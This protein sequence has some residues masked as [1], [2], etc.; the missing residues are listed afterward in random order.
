M[1]QTQSSALFKETWPEKTEAAT[2]PNRPCAA[3]IAAAVLGLA[4]AWF[5]AG[6]IGMM[7]HPMHRGAA[8]IA[9][10]MAVV[11]AWPQGG[12]WKSLL[13]ILAVAGA[14]AA[15]LMSSAILPLNVLAVALVLVALSLGHTSSSKLALQVAAESVLLLA[16]FRIAET[17]IPWVWSGADGL[18][19]FLGTI[20]SLMSAKPLWVGATFG[21]LDFL[22]PMLYLAI[23]APLRM[24][25]S[26]TLPVGRA[27][28]ATAGV[29]AVVSVLLV[30]LVALSYAPSILELPRMQ[31]EKVERP[32]AGAT[33]PPP[34]MKTILRLMIPWNV[35]LLAG[36]FEAVV[37]VC[38]LRELRARA[39]EQSLRGARE[40]LW[41]MDMA[42]LAIVLAVAAP[43]AVVYHTR[44]PDMR[45]KKIV[46]HE[47]GFL[48]WLKPEHGQYGRLSIGMYG[49]M[50]TYLQSLGARTK[51]SP[52]LSRE[53]LK[54]A[55]AVVLLFSNERWK[56]GQLE[57]LWAFVKG[58]GTLLVMGEH[59][60]CEKDVDGNRYDPA[61]YDLF[62]F[63]NQAIEPTKMRVRFDAA[64]FAIGGWLHSYD[65][66]AHPTTAGIGD[67]RNEIGAVIGASV[68]AE[69]PARPLVVGRWGW[70]DAGDTRNT[71]RAMLGDDKYNAGE[72]LGDVLL[73]AEQP[74]GRGKVIV[75]GDTSGLTNGLTVGCHPYTSRLYA[76][77]CDGTTGALPAWTFAVSLA[78]LSAVTLVV[79][80]R[81]QP[82]V[83]AA[84]A[85]A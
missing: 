57:R 36:L 33:P 5:A 54:D 1:A 56:A 34:P 25:R 52:D 44:A 14:A 48:N 27:R 72:K 77:L 30:Y 46:M 42:A 32:V 41:D 58:G 74:F 19:G 82:M 24:D 39:G 65:P 16:L 12:R 50:E 3:V 31:A 23:A 6:S 79:V 22:V 38:I 81:P 76:Y 62:N 73:A 4:G 10:L 45:G 20:A 40:T 8:V 63:F 26:P 51:I 17:T 59:T 28:L 2:V 85:E 70:C 53:D 60:I 29:A 78:L 35:P 43:A 75:F 11:L 37:A 66:M 84:T 21:G 69:W 61:T 55:D 67:D 80:L 68:S 83:V 15:W 7:S 47:K 9:M 18:G 13:P 64:T 49:M 71:N